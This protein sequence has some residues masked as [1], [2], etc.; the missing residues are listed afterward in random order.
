ME[1][2]N[3]KQKQNENM[4]VVKKMLIQKKAVGTQH[5]LGLIPQTIVFFVILAC[6]Y[7]LFTSAFSIKASHLMM[8]IFLM[9]Y[10][11]LISAYYG[12]EI[13][14][15]IRIKVFMGCVVSN[16][17]LL[18]VTGRQFLE[19]VNSFIND[20]LLRINHSYNG[21][22]K[23]L[24]NAGND[25]TYF[26]FILFFWI[27]IFLGKGLIE[28]QDYYHFLFL[29]F[30]VVILVLLSGGQVSL[31]VLFILFLCF[32]TVLASAS[33]NVR[34]KFWG[35]ENSKEFIKN[36][37]AS[38]RIRNQLIFH[39]IFVGTIITIACA[40]LFVPGITTPMEKLS[41]MVS[42]VKTQG[43]QLLYEFLP[44][45]SGGKLS[46]SL[47]GAGGGVS[48]GELGTVAGLSYDK[49]EALKITCSRAPEE[50]IYLKGFIGTDY[51]GSK[52]SERSEGELENAIQNWRVENN[53]VIYIHNLP[54]LRMMYAEQELA[55]ETGDLVST[56]N[57]ITVE[58][59]GANI[60]YTYVPYQSF[61]NDYYIIEGG[62]CSVVGQTLQDDIYAW[63]ST[64]S[65]QNIMKQWVV[66]PH[67]S[68]LD[69]I[70]TAYE[71]Y[72][73]EQD[74][75]VDKEELWELWE[76]CKE[77][78]E[79]WDKRFS[80]E[81]TEEQYQVLQEE[82]YSDIKSFIV[83]NLWEECT[84]TT[85][86][87]K[88]PEGENFVSY[89]W[90]EKKRGDSTAFASTAVMMY[91]M[92]DI[93]ARYVV[94]Y[95]APAN[96]FFTTSTGECSAILQNDNAHAWVEIYMSDFGWVPVE[97]T[98]GF[99]GTVS[100]MEVKEEDL[101]EE[102]PEKAEEEIEETENE[103]AWEQMGNIKKVFMIVSVL[104]GIIAIFL[105]RRL[106]VKAKRRGKIGKCSH[107]Q[108]IKIIF[109]SFY[110][111]LLFMEF[112]KETDTTEP[113]FVYE[114]KKWYDE[115]EEKQLRKYMDSVMA[116]HYGKINV[117]KTDVLFSLEMYERLVRLSASRLK[118]KK[119]FMFTFWKVF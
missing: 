107:E 13:K 65:Y 106:Y 41:D 43:M 28:N 68:L 54:F 49:E 96:L 81:L 112:P 58:R 57:Q 84:F 114:V 79:T 105:V 24:D 8:H 86:V 42:P 77:K 67:H 34:K 90:N 11:F 22:L 108:Q 16:L 87:W 66:S 113:E 109:C 10:S 64:K 56:P 27:G 33:T 52:W 100:N 18:L 38:R 17:L 36:K 104:V 47:E 80:G 97:T 70:E 110:Q 48:G 89:F 76:L 72:V 50:I 60:D 119:K 75:K 45:V 63:Y 3:L 39:S 85:E 5:W 88:L 2:G 118:G 20:M 55:K 35:G 99:E 51:S 83:S 26:L 4:T 101:P 94:G 69:D 46:F 91:R 12:S 21:S 9:M 92:F 19:S 117:T 82:K 98:P 7:H 30:P 15:H 29:C 71:S 102:K 25:G 6:I 61:L 103:N 44:K 111:L 23:L 53:S 37:E 62:D 32:L 73:Q 1:T 78:K 93:P 95:A 59:L 116:V 31:P 40:F 115:M 14:S 74:T